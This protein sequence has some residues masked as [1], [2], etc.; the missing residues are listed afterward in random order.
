MKFV[1]FS[2]LA[3]AILLAC[4][5]S[6]ADPVVHKFELWGKITNSEKIHL[7]FGWTNGFFQSRGPRAKELL[8]C[9]EKM[10]TTQAMAMI[11]KHYNDHPE[12]WS[13]PIGEQIL[14]AMTAEGEGGPCQGKNPLALR[15]DLAQP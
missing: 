12:L 4:A 15:G 6:H 5:V 13:H 1:Q 9:L 8:T 2:M 10:P 11:D 14:D 3:V 7:Y